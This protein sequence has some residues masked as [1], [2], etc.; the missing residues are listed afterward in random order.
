MFG[1]RQAFLALL[2]FAAALSAP[3]RAGDAPPPTREE[4]R[5]LQQRLAD[6]GCYKGA[7]DGQ[8]D[9][10]LDAAIK[11]CPDQR[12]FLRIETGMHTADIKRIGVDLECRRIATASDDKTVRI[13]SLPE[14]RLERTIRFPI[15]DGNEGKAYAVALSPDGRF[16]VA[17]GWDASWSRL[18]TM[19]LTIIDLD[20][21]ATRRIGTFPSDIDQIALSPDGA[22]IAVGL[23]GKNG[24]RILDSGMGQEIADTDYDADIYGI[25]FAPDGSLL[26]T[27]FDGSVRRYDPTGKRT[28]KRVALAGARPYSVAIDPT[29]RRAAIGYDGNPHISIVDAKSLAPIAEAATSDLKQND[30]SSLAWSRDGGVLIAG[31]TAKV[32]KDGA[33]RRILRRFGPD[34]LR[35]GDDEPAAYNSISDIQRCGDGFAFAAADPNFGL[36]GTRGPVRLLQTPQ[37]ADMRDKI[38]SAFEISPDATKVRFGLGSG[39]RQP[40]LFDLGGGALS[41]SSNAPKGLAAPRTDGMTVTDWQDSYAPKL[42]GA[43]LPLDD[44]ERSRSLSVRPDA[45]GFVVGADYWIRAFDAS[46]VERLRLPGPGASWGVNLSADGEIVV[47]AY[48]DGAIRWLRWSDGV[49]LLALFVEPQSRKW[50]AW[51]PTGYYM[52]SPGGED[53]IGWHLNRGW[54]QLADFFPAS[55]FS[56]RFNRPDIVKLALTTRDEAEAVRRANDA[57]KHKT[58]STSIV[59]RL[60]PVVTITTPKGD[61]AFDST[62]V[63]VAFDARSPSGLTVDRVEALIDGRP[64]EAS[65]LAAAGPGG[66][67]KLTLPVPP[68]DVEISIIARAGDLVGEPARVRLKYAG[69]APQDVLKPKLYAVAIGVSDYADAS[70]KLT[71]AADDARGVAE[72]LQRQQGGL[73]SHVE[74]RTILNADATRVAVIEALDWLQGQ[75]T[76]RDIGMVMIAGHGV[77]DEKGRYWFLPSDAAVKH[78]AATA[79][80]QDDLRRSLGSIA[81]KAVLFLDTCHA[82]REV[83]TRGFG[84]AGVDVASLVNDFAKT[85]NGLVTFAATQGAELAQESPAWGQ[86]A[87]SLALIEGVGEGKADL[88]HKGEITVSALDYYI[89]ERVKTLTEG[90][91]H[92]VMS[93]PDTV[94]DF[95][96]AMKR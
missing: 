62:S 19:S 67:R 81:G 30:L 70:L 27:S 12:P 1:F 94:P 32:S 59:A 66:A 52:A 20:T 53:L 89:A 38:G 23:G 49:E 73:Y 35:I 82:N 33:W 64:V 13:W 2:A 47:V 96:F 8:A 57:A 48:D 31:G 72:A 61:G 55:R 56:D 76:S 22:R 50:V 90:R 39:E 60:P 11:A 91:Q 4:T 43:K 65:G 68:R 28:A 86:G 16:V 36:I 78:L 80:S 51:T 6:A 10:N 84:P 29:G 15:G 79:V 77:T 74:V 71:Y 85:E 17:G 5:I 95:A 46:G 83:S 42:R 75:V 93:R 34:G 37:T 54:T 24:L 14:G 63:D 21:G 26:A 87:F 25:A 41:D 3:A 9:A 40:V 7:I 44:F 58:D 18:N 69:A 88:L 45:K 92:P